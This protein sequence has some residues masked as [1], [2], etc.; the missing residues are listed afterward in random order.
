MAI[1]GVIGR[2]TH[3]LIMRVGRIEPIKTASRICPL[4]QKNSEHRLDPLFSVSIYTFILDG[5]T[6]GRLT[7]VLT[8]PPPGE[9]F[10]YLRLS[11]Y[12]L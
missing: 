9:I 12:L 4:D 10:L 6:I 7:I 5:V 1:G 2:H 3:V 11:R 8:E